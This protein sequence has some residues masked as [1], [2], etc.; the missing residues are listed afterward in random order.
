MTGCLLLA[1]LLA[2]VF[3]MRVVQRFP[4]KDSVVLVLLL[5]VGGVVPLVIAGISY[6]KEIMYLVGKDPTLTGRT[7]IW[8]AVVVAAMKRPLL[9]YGYKAFW[10]GLQGESG[11]VL[12]SNGWSFA[13]AHNGF[14]EVWLDCALGLG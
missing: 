7:T 12:M 10:T 9:G 14:L 6:F 11:N 5:M 8:R 13:Q 2:Y 4:K 1:F 3:V